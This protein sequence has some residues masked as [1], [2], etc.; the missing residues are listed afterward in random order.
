MKKIGEWAFNGTKLSEDGIYF[1][2]SLTDY[3]DIEI[4]END[5]GTF[6]NY[7]HLSDDYSV[8]GFCGNQHNVGYYS[9]GDG[10][11]YIVGHGE[12]KDYPYNNDIYHHDKLSSP[13]TLAGYTSI[14]ISE[15]ITSIGDFAFAEKKSADS[16]IQNVTL[17]STL[18][19][20][21]Q[22]AFYNCATLLP[23]VLPENLEKIGNYAFYGC[24]NLAD[25]VIDDDI[26]VGL[27]ATEYIGSEATIYDKS[28]S[29]MDTAVDYLENAYSSGDHPNLGYESDFVL[30]SEL[31]ILHALAEDL[32]SKCT[33]DEEKCMAIANW[34]KNNITYG[35]TYS[36][37]LP[38]DVIRRGTA[39]CSGYA[40][41]FT[42][43]VRL[44]GVKSAVLRGYKYNINGNSL[45]VFYS[46]Y[47]SYGHQWSLAYYDGAWH[48]FDVLWTNL[49][50][51]GETSREVMASC[52]FVSQV[53][54]VALN[55]DY[56]YDKVC[57][58]HRIGIISMIYENG[59]WTTTRKIA[60]GSGYY[61]KQ[62]G[63]GIEYSTSV[64]YDG[65]STIGTVN[66][67][68]TYYDSAHDR[69]EKTHINGTDVQYS[70]VNYEGKNVLI[71]AGGMQNTLVTDAMLYRCSKD[72]KLILYKGECLSVWDMF[73]PSYFTAGYTVYETSN[74]SVLALDGDK[75]TV[76]GIGDADITIK[77]G[78]RTHSLSFTVFGGKQ[79]D[80]L[81]VLTKYC[82]H[83]HTC[84]I[85]G[86][87]GENGVHCIERCVACGEAVHEY[88]I[89]GNFLL[90]KTDD[91]YLVT[92]LADADDIQ[93]ACVA[94]DADGRMT[95]LKMASY[96]MK[97][98]ETVT[99][100]AE[101][102]NSKLFVLNSNFLPMNVESR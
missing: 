101:E 19:E 69:V 50:P 41:L 88:D 77:N 63:G 14:V 42:T 1:T 62:C 72:K 26:T 24:A 100:I 16:T 27:C 76:V 43:L 5:W 34:I 66:S 17:P 93:I 67:D 6:D 49:I 40:N 44:V 25:L 102:E 59:T 71:G 51:F 95:D 56:A 10:T 54:G 45:N 79:T 36:S 97:K 99:V 33:T 22:Y 57:G 39:I 80:A 64:N 75:I 29:A 46:T 13:F 15:G 30:T 82:A 89:N 74:N 31:T 38:L 55:D 58:I 23:P 18:T 11:L 85:V 21:S 83:E 87:E 4:A 94:Y 2:G 78:Y 84:L 86:D 9:Y 53:D 60:G 98:S 81:G 73:D 35:D 96:N 47:G 37:Q 32:T 7:L 12:M 68:L 90:R 92:A 52:Y 3:L 28:K 8:S 61:S 91:A 20:I 48:N 70:T 65:N